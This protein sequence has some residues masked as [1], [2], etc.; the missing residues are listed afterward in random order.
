V[1][2]KKKPKQCGSI[3]AKKMEETA[4]FVM[5]KFSSGPDHNACLTTVPA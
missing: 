1:Q 2:I 3:I 4:E 5:N